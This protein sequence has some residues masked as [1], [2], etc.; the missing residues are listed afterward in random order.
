MSHNNGFVSNYKDSDKMFYNFQINLIPELQVCKQRNEQDDKTISRRKGIKKKKEK[1]IENR[2]KLRSFVHKKTR[3]RNKSGTRI[4][5]FKTD[6][7]F[8]EKIIKLEQ[9]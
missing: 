9:K 8:Q 5:V 6:K 4:P 2:R 7:V 1:L 3:Y